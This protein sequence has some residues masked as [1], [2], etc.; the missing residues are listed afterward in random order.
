MSNTEIDIASI[1]KDLS[2]EFLDPMHLI[3]Q[4]FSETYNSLAENVH[5][6]VESL[7]SVTTGK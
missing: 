5:I 3:T 6:I 7:P 1:A 4:Y 2:M